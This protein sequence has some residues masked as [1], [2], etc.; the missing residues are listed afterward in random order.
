M[1]LPA[2]PDTGTIPRTSLPRRT[3]VTETWLLL[4]LSL[5]ASALWSLLSLVDKL[6]KHIALDRQ[7]T[8]MNSSVTPDRPWL[9]LAYQLLPIALGILRR[10]SPSTSC[11]GTIPAPRR[12]SD[13]T[14]VARVATSRGGPPSREGSAYPVWVCMPPPAPSV[15]TPPS[16]R[17]IS[18]TTGGASGPRARGRAERGSRGGRHDRLPPDPVATGWLVRTR[19]DRCLRPR[20][21][22]LPPLSG[23]RRLR[24]ERG[25]GP[26]VRIVLRAHEAGVAPRGGPHPARR[27]RLRRLHAA[28]I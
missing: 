18:R 21:G 6:T 10:F 11:A 13:W 4:G 28:A 20:P 3:L 8:A 2:L 19:G 12:R 24:R 7:T 27:G 15:S 26:P 14:G 9:D 17:P 1:P 25:H 22:R 16:R 5:G 23:V